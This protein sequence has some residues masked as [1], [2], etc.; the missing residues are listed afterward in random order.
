MADHEFCKVE[1]EGRITIVTLNR[2]DVM[3]ALHWPAHFELE[4]VWD[5]FAA[6]PEQWVAIVTGAG[7]RAFA[8]GNDLQFHAAGN[9]ISRARPGFAGRTNRSDLEQPWMAAVNGS[10]TGW[11]VELA[12]TGR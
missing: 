3:N 11:G 9:K 1:K 12:A 2:P 5:E 10:P 4:Q 6:D 8:A 7:D